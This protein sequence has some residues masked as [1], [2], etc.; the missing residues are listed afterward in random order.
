M[1]VVFLM[2]EPNTHA[3][4]LSRP[5]IA[6]ISLFVLFEVIEFSLPSIAVDPLLRWISEDYTKRLL[7]LSIIFAQPTFRQSIIGVLSRPWSP[8]EGQMYGH[9]RLAAIV[10]GLCIAEYFIIRF[11]V[12]SFTV[13]PD[14][15]S[16]HLPYSGEPFFSELSF[17]VLM[18][19]DLT[20]GLML[21]SLS[22]ECVFRAI[23]YAALKKRNLS[24]STIIL[25]SSVL[26]GLV[27]LS[28]GLPN[29]FAA[30]LTGA[31][32]MYAFIKTRSLW[33][34]LVAHYIINYVVFSTT[35]ETWQTWQTH[36]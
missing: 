18:W 27:H 1:V 13:L 4:R 35:W 7:I 16:I 26:F 33:P 3:V 20:V 9:I 32:F 21:V 5:E 36:W 22:E 31:I 14:I 29:T 28:K 30:M 6:L 23:A 10:I 15:T 25:I 11:E 17:T 24:D 2:T 8:Y 19:F 12:W 34:T